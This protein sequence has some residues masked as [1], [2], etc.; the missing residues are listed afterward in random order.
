MRV[1]VVGRSPEKMDAAIAVLESH[2]FTA[3]GVFSEQEAACAIAE[4][5]ELVAVVAGGSI[6]EP[7]Q[8]RLRAA[9]AP[10]GAVLITAYIGH[11][12]PTGHFTNHVIPK[13]ADP[14]DRAHQQTGEGLPSRGSIPGL[15]D[16]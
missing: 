2:G 12:D 13:L 16:P 8:E 6:D 11:D 9:A 5:D 15:G 14:R 1:I 10:K 4:Q 3:T 7:A